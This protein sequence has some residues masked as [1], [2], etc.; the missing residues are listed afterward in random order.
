MS[1]IQKVTGT[2]AAANPAGGSL[3]LS[4][5]TAG[6]TLVFLSSYTN[7]T[8]VIPTDSS[9]Q[10]WTRVAVYTNTNASIEAFYL[11]NANAGTHTLT[12]AP[13]AGGYYNTA[14]CEIP[15]TNG[16]DVQSSG[17]TNGKGLITTLQL[18]PLR[19][20]NAT[21]AVFVAL[22]SNDTGTTANFGV[23]DPPAGLTSIY[24]YQLSTISE[25]AAFSYVET[26]SAQVISP[27]WTW[28]PLSTAA[29]QVAFAFAFKL[30]P[31]PGRFAPV[32]GK[33]KKKE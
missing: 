7:G 19:T 21:D 10:T 3:V 24:A 11:E 9:G 28:N 22:S 2:T 26:T 32:K 27:V 15:P 20:T 12:Y 18:L 14:F 5:V 30:A 13:G 23:T 29:T 4:G 33:K 1:I 17:P 25:C 8:S 6:N 16:L 31:T